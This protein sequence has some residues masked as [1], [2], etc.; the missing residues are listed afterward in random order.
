MMYWYL[1]MIIILRMY[2]IGMYWYYYVSLASLLSLISVMMCYHY[3][4]YYIA[5]DCLSVIIVVV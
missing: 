2:T 5:I 1:L 3:W 4:Y